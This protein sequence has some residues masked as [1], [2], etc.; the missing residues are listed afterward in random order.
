M[1][2]SLQKK[3]AMC[4]LSKCA[5]AQGPVFNAYDPA[6]A[7][8]QVASC[9]LGFTDKQCMLRLSKSEVSSLSSLFPFLRSKENPANPKNLW[10]GYPSRR[11]A[12]EPVTLS[13]EYLSAF[14][15]EPS[16]VSA[17]L[18]VAKPKMVAII[19]YI[20]ESIVSSWLRVSKPLSDED[21]LVDERRHLETEATRSLVLL[22]SEQMTGAAENANVW[23]EVIGKKPVYVPLFKA[24][25]F[26][27]LP[28]LSSHD[29]HG[30]S[31]VCSGR[32]CCA[33]SPCGGCHMW[34]CDHCGECDECWPMEPVESLGG[35]PV[36]SGRSSC[37]ASPCGGCQE[38][39]CYHCGECDKCCSMLCPSLK[40]GGN[41][42]DF[43]LSE[44]LVY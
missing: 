4:S 33:V 15:M 1:G 35:S 26:P 29:E 10:N 8:C 18:A 5:N 21:L 40:R 13:W 32:S 9:L 27:A 37:A 43:P 30:C 16:K 20:V 38:W 7:G 2:I 6:K 11:W 25:D 41:C 22:S 19:S 42:P 39:A 24:E 34:S 31:S 17:A 14:C 36:S 44:V 12:Y 3:Q 23:C 28:S